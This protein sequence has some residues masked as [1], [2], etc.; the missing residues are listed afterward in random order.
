[1]EDAPPPLVELAPADPASAEAE[2]CIRAYFAELNARS[3]GGFDPATSIGLAP[4]QLR[5]PAALLLL[6]RVGGEAV[7]CGAVRH[8]GDGAAEIRRMWVAARARGLGIGRRMLGELEAWARASGA[9][10][11]RLETNGALTEAIALYRSAGY[12]DV[13]AFNDEPF[14]HHWFEKPLTPP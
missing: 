6:A 2:R 4:Q 1:M 13:P 11:A 3:G 7:G 12:R 10:V 9:R 5:P 14:A 8:S